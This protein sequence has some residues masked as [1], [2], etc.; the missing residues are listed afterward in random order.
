MKY[1]E[2]PILNHLY[3]RLDLDARQPIPLALCPREEIVHPDKI[4]RLVTHARNI[5]WESNG[6]WEW[7]SVEWTDAI[8]FSELASCY[9]YVMG[10]PGLREMIQCM[11][12]IQTAQ[13]FDAWFQ[14]YA[15][16]YVMVSSPVFENKDRR[17]VFFSPKYLGR[18]IHAP[19]AGAEGT[20]ASFEELEY[21]IDFKG[22][23]VASG[24]ILTL[25]M[26]RQ[27][28]WKESMI[29]PGIRTFVQQLQAAHVDDEDV[30]A[31]LIPDWDVRWNDFY[32][33]H[34]MQICDVP[35]IYAMTGNGASAEIQELL[36]IVFNHPDCFI[37]HIHASVFYYVTPKALGFPK[38]TWRHWYQ[39]LLVRPEIELD[40]ESERSS[41]ETRPD[42]AGYLLN[43]VSN[44]GLWKSWVRSSYQFVTINDIFEVA[45]HPDR[46]LTEIMTFLFH[47]YQ[48]PYQNGFGSRAIRRRR[49]RHIWNLVLEKYPDVSFSWFYRKYCMRTI[50]SSKAYLPVV[51]VGFLKDFLTRL[52]HRKG[53]FNAFEITFITERAS[54][55]LLRSIFQENIV[56]EDSA[57]IASAARVKNKV[58][59]YDVWKVLAQFR[60][61][62][63]VIVEQWIKPRI[64][65][66]MLALKHACPPSVYHA[67]AA[68][69]NRPENRWKWM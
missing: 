52:R 55:E 24:M 47:F 28:A 16:T 29:L 65:H 44:H 9:F 45:D 61:E 37:Q 59:C 6:Q 25:A 60:L 38:I 40:D 7:C 5:Q 39:G 3:I 46:A 54:A 17:H 21:M 8:Y 20:G 43:L 51:P 18:A 63:A 11:S 49:L 56:I 69:M 27:G 48:D 62:F 26:N 64:A 41:I 1:M 22:F 15:K 35:S 30:S 10:R 58:S 42:V 66:N 13:D 50:A 12:M 67:V 33:E 19:G 68:H 34:V 53:F 4:M 57:V 2:L 14:R 31:L 36:S 32:H 23:T